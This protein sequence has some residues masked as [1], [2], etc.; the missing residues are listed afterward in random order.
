MSD[1]STMD[2]TRPLVDG[3]GRRHDNLR[4]S[5]TDRCNIRCFYCMPEEKPVF[6]PRK[7]IL[8]Y[9]E[10]LR[11]VRVAAGLGIEKI[12]LTGGEPLVRRDVDQLV[13]EI[14]RLPGIRDVALTTN[15]LLLAGQAPALRAAGLRRVN[16]HLDT[17]DPER[18]RRI[19][20]RDGLEAVLA[21][22]DRARE[23]GFS[24]IKLNAVTV[25]GLTEPDLAPMARFGREKGIQVRFIEY[26]PLDADRRWRRDQVLL[27]GD[28]LALIS[29][30]I[31]PLSPS[32][33][34]DPRSPASDFD[35]ADGV[36]GIGIIA[37]ISRPFC[38]SCN[39]LRLTAEGMLRNCLFA[40]DELDA[41]S[42]LRGGGSDAAIADLI[43]RSVGAK[44]EGHDINTARFL[45][46]AR[47]MHA[48][49]G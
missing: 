42:L 49:G 15:G 34:Q 31:A 14:V 37:S 39:R 29:R 7:E 24:P 27:A 36:G 40:R 26:M 44:L 5:L 22:I 20:G 10:I 17:L 16:V 41:R 32:P 18:F 47:P 9:E 2:D 11:F 30:E 43:R 35:F 3:F 38:A 25:K 45:Q 23:L 28:I 8:T 1:D 12:R 19:S 6:V 13:R 33:G 21:G 46:P 4:I 48:I